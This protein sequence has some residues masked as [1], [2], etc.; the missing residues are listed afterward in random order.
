ML[1]DKRVLA[2]A[3]K[4]AAEQEGKAVGQEWD[5]NDIVTFVSQVDHNACVS[6]L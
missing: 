1:K 6:D 3:Q 5:M 2:L 4:K